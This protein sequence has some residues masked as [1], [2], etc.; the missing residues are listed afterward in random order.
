MIITN[1]FDLI[2]FYRVE[3]NNYILDTERRLLSIFF[4]KGIIFEKEDNTIDTSF[5]NSL[6]V[7]TFTDLIYL[8]LETIEYLDKKKMCGFGETKEKI[9]D[10]RQLANSDKDYD[11]YPFSAVM[12]YP[13]VSYSTWEIDAFEFSLSFQ[14]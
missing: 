5:I 2:D 11:I 3:I 6:C 12:T 13:I 10:S 14:S 4:S 8:K 7:G 9:F 1:D